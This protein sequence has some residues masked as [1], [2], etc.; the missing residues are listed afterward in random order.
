LP[1]VRS[2]DPFASTRADCPTVPGGIEDTAFGGDEVDNLPGAPLPDVVPAG[3][4]LPAALLPPTP[5]LGADGAFTGAE[6]ACT[7]GV[8][9]LVPWVGMFATDAVIPPITTAA[10]AATNTTR[11]R[12]VWGTTVRALDLDGAIEL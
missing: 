9:E 11:P 4:L 2:T 10:I 7:P 5:P 6:A 8:V 3:A 1:I 12:R